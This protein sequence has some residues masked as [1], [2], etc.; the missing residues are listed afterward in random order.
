MLDFESSI[1]VLKELG[2][3]YKMNPII[4]HSMLN[5]GLEKWVNPFKT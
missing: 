3:L 4:V 5:I 2:S 1:M